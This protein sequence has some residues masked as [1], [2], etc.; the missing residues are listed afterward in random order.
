MDE[1]TGPRARRTYELLLAVARE[2]FAEN[3]TDASLRDI[4]RRADVGIGTLYRHFPT[5]EALLEALLRKRFDELRE[6]AQA[7]LAAPCPAPGEALLTWLG[8]LSA[9]SS[10]YR[11]LPQ[12]VMAAL[13]DE[14]SQL[15]A[16]CAAMRTSAGQLL[17]RAQQAG[18]V[19]A[20]VTAEELLALAAG[21][22]WA[23]EQSTG[24]TDLVHRLLSIAMHGL[25]AT[26]RA[27]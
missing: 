1:P 24:Q 25:T 5:R 9:G 11:G 18:A 4:A 16:S 14:S 17:H 23:S 10:T 12:S 26:D 8:E 6:S 21:V 15:H 7:M 3:G 27:G 22:A 13:R 2:A 19:R 20:D